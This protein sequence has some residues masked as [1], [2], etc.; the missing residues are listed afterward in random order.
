[1]SEEIL[2]PI[3]VM[4]EDELLAVITVNREKFN[5]EYK[6][7]VTEELE[8]RGVNL[9]EKFR[10]VRMKFNLNEVEEVDISEVNE[11][12]S[13]LKKPIDVLYF[14]N[15]MNEHYAVQKNKNLFVVHHHAPKSGFK[16][17]FL[18][19][20]ESLKTSLQNFLTLNNWLPDGVE[21][22]EHWET[23]EESASPDYI[24]KLAEFMDESEIV[25]CVNSLQNVRFNSNNSPYAIVLPVDEVSGAEEIF[26]KMEQLK[27][28]LHTKLEEAESKDDVELQLNILKELESVT[29]EDSL[30]F[31]IKAQLLDEKGDYQN[32]SDALIESFN[33]EMSNGAVDDIDDIENYLVSIIDK[34]DNK[35]N[36]LHCLATISAFK[37]EVDSSAEYYEKIIKLDEND[38]MAHLHLGHHYY[39]NTEDDENVKIHFNKYLEL[40]PKSE[41]RD[42]IEEILNNL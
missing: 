41:E 23:F 38:S 24:L 14:I 37:G 3:D 42:A 21:V 36:S 16:S 17:F 15:I 18:E 4:S 2:K 9:E 32:A 19:I 13:L 40:E 33:I 35:I 26:D 1:M 31:Y 11:R 6:S 30:V 25:Y 22:I 28:S 27:E 20:E 29:P 34:I 5:D 10:T 12:I 39:S 7:K 8:K